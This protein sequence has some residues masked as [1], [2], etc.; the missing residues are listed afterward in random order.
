M[1]DYA[2]HD[3]FR[4]LTWDDLAEWAGS[5]TVN[6]GRSYQRGGR[7]QKIERTPDHRLVSWVEGTDRYATMVEMEDLKLTS[8]CSCPYFWAPC[9]HAVAVVVEYL[10]Q[11]KKGARVPVCDPNDERLELLAEIRQTV[12]ESEI[13]DDEDELTPPSGAT[14]QRLRLDPVATYLE[15]LSRDELIALIRDLTACHPSVGEKLNDLAVLESG[16][17]Q[18]LVSAIRREIGALSA[19]PGWSRHWSNESYVPDY[20]RVRE[21]LEALLSRG[22][23]DEVLALG[24]ELLDKGVEQVGMSD[25]DGQTHDELASAMDLVFRALPLSS[26]APVEQMLWVINAE[27]KDEFE[28]C[29]GARTFWDLPHTSGE[30]SELANR[31]L[32]RLRETQKP[33]GETRFHDRYARDRLT[34]W[35]I[36]TL[37]ESA[38]RDE[39]IPLCRA[40]APITASYERLVKLLIDA[41]ELTEAEDWIQQGIEATREEFPGI[42]ASLSK[43]RIRIREDRED[44]PGVT[45]LRAEE[46]LENPSLETYKEL[47]DAS[48]RAG[49]WETVRSDAIS[50][51]ET[52]RLEGSSPP[53]PPSSQGPAKPGHPQGS[54][55]PLGRILID[56]HIEENNPAAVLEWYQKT[57]SEKYGWGFGQ[58]DRVARC[59][60]KT[61]PDES[62]AVWKRL[63]EKE[64]A[65][66]NPNAYL[67]AGGYLRK[68]RQILQGAGRKAEWSAYI[69]EIRRTNARKKR[70]M[71][72]LDGLDRRP[73]VE[74]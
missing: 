66:T 40:E 44:W 26:M 71:E 34:N 53:W 3:P 18:T 61:H 56:L 11:L 22:H 33:K 17:V 58:E 19:E 54:Q 5:K 74:H 41:G 46:F 73:I 42:A 60:S 47:R 24:K 65:L 67:Q 43:S 7:V 62:I 70:L 1:T 31:L 50:Y 35:I 28:L 68:I 9:K 30:W 45:M 6:K 48:A 59:L 57:R 36:L 10:D 64:I 37:Q 49:L 55:F 52:G 21:R 51:L 39:I 27:L 13:D 63:A 72:V 12:D 32:A 14:K 69:G 15:N 8:L 16:E 20:S 4:D 38:R 23:A 25:D 2:N 29:R